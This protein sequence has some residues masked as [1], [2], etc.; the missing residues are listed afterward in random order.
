MLALAAPVLL[1]LFPV[2][3]A[4]RGEAPRGNLPAV[5]CTALQAGPQGF[6]AKKG[7]K[8]GSIQVSIQFY[9][10][11][12]PDAPVTRRVRELLKADRS[13]SISSWG[14]IR[15]PAGSGNASLIMAIAGRTAPDIMNS[16]F[17]IIRNDIKQGFLYPL[18][19]WIGEDKNGN[20]RIDDDEAVWA[21][22]KSIPMLWRHV[23]TV[24][25]KVYGL[26]QASYAYMGIIFRTDLVQAAGL[27]PENPP[28]TWDELIYWCQ[29]LTDPGKQISGAVY[30]R[31]QRGI[32]IMPYGFTWLPW[33]QSAGGSPIV[34][35]RKDP[36]TGKEYLFPMEATAFITP[37]GKDLAVAEPRWH[38]DFT[39]AAAMAAAELYHRLRWMKWLRDPQTKEPVNLTEADM[40]NGYV[41]SNGRK[42][43]FTEQDVIAGVARSAMG[44]RDLGP[45]EMLSRGE[46]AMVTWFVSDLSSFASYAKLDPDLLSWFPFPAGPGPDG[47]RVV[48]KQNHYVTLCEAVGDRP[49]NERDKI[50]KILTAVT[51]QRISDAYVQEKILSGL[52]RFVSP[53]DLQRL[54]FADYLKDVPPMI[55]RNF[56]DIESGGIGVFTEP[57][58]GFWWPADTALNQQVLSMVLS[59][60]GEN[61]DYRA[62]LRRVELNANSGLMFG[63]TKAELDQYRPTAR[64]LFILMACVILAFSYFIIRSFWEKKNESSKQVYKGYLPWLLLA[65]A[66]VLIALWSYYPLFRGMVMAFQDYRIAGESRFVGLDNFIVLALDRSWWESLGRTVYFVFLNMVL[67]FLF[68][69]FLALLLSEVPRG[70]IFY[71]TLFFLPQVSSGIVIALMWKLMYDPT[72]AGFLNQ[73]IAL[74]N[75]LPLVNLPTQTW[76]ENPQLAM[77]CC[78]IPTVWATMG[79]ASLIY[80]AALHSIPAELY[81]AADLDGAGV[82]HKIRSITFP[83]LLPLIII[84]FVGA[85]I[86]TFQNMG[87]IF[88]LTF[89]GPGEVTTVAGLRIWQE[90]YANLR[91]SM[92]TSMAWVLGS[93]LIGFTYLQIRILRKVEFKKAEWT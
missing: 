58:M 86:G 69:I 88:L 1:A 51:D 68:P 14:G 49:K 60:S 59:E 21:G 12:Y 23:A 80:L 72:P 5:L 4:E 56:A 20:G 6:L 57:Y 75:K 61:F 65:P 36:A 74:L 37:D 62:A 77:L 41:T 45:W 73:V 87:N 40:H 85:F 64:M 31:G 33:I 25:G 71:R 76:L 84:N 32:V 9:T 35:A 82:F 47:R 89:G 34:Q 7:E 50:W 52:A 90:A 46:V 92:A 44:Q 48:Q 11:N 70:K 66:L 83:T 43:D 13:L 67:A 10:P 3:G 78:V 42:I 93:I 17:H 81:E 8:D 19:E 39:S 26:P 28:Q 54:G 22:W 16:Y 29:R 30:Q 2:Q 38:A 27:D 79:M 15:L 18:N 24:G 55:R 91:F 63:R 53:S